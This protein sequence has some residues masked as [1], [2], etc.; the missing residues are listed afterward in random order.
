[1]Y[2]LMTLSLVEPYFTIQVVSCIILTIKSLTY[3]HFFPPLSVF[4]TNALTDLFQFHLVFFVYL[5]ASTV[6]TKVE[7]YFYFVGFTS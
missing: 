6:L 4:M 3:L 5:D 2:E 7:N 1:M